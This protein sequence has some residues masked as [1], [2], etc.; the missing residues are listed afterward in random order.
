MNFQHRPWTAQ[1]DLVLAIRLT[2]CSGSSPQNTSF[3]A[4]SMCKMQDISKPPRLPQRGFNERCLHTTPACQGWKLSKVKH[5][6]PSASHFH[7][8]QAG[9][10]HTTSMVTSTLSL[11]LLGFCVLK[12]YQAELTADLCLPQRLLWKHLEKN[13]NVA[14][15]PSHLDYRKKNVSAPQGMQND[16]NLCKDL[17]KPS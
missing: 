7:G 16:K 13:R 12:H 3:V 2:H 15:S 6:P 14:D 1:D 5:V 9:A 10:C 4:S 11:A 8:C 17:K